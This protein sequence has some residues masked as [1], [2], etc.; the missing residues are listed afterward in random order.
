MYLNFQTK[1][2][3]I[4]ELKKHTI[5]NNNALSVINNT[6]LVDVKE[7]YI[8]IT[9]TNL[10]ETL[11]T[12][13]QT[14]SNEEFSFVIDKKFLINALQAVNK[15]DGCT[16][17]IDTDKSKLFIDTF[18]LNYISS[19]LFPIIPENK[20]FICE[21]KHKT[22]KSMYQAE[23]F[24]VDNCRDYANFLLFGIEN[25]NHYVSATDSKIIFFNHR[26]QKELDEAYLIPKSIIN[27]LKKVNKYNY[28]V[29]FYRVNKGV[30]S[31]EF[32]GNRIIY[33]INTENLSYPK[34]NYVMNRHELNNSLYLDIKCKEFL[35]SVLK[36]SP[37][38]KETLC[39]FELENGKIKI[40]YKH[41][42]IGELTQTFDTETNFKEPFKFMLNIDLLLKIFL[43]DRIILDFKNATTPFRT[44]LND[45][46]MYIMPCRYE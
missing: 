31:I 16:I 12:K 13:T 5:K 3:L 35:K 24:L 14:N 9:S 28:S 45:Y 46:V 20:E 11:I 2:T 44:T 7:G 6:V 1:N 42:E 4:A 37:D 38:K 39:L 25:N 23:K 30:Y 15:N 18:S 27:L 36:L 32:T 22:L 17:I 19:E 41:Y 21:I 34:L 10:N 26:L 33:S 8:F 43:E 40:T 29:K